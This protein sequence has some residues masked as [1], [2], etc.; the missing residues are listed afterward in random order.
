MKAE[1][2][3]RRSPVGLVI[4]VS[5]VV[6]AVGAAYWVNRRGHLYPTS[7]DATIDA[8]VVHV[9]PS[10]PGRVIELPV[11]ENQLVAR[12]DLLFRLDPEHY[13]HDVRQAEADL[14]LARAEV[15]TQRRLIATETA[16]LAVVQAQVTKARTNYDLSFRTV[17]RLRP[18][19]DK[20]FVPTQQFDQAEVN[21]RDMATSLVQVTAQERA[22]RSA[23]GKLDA[24][25]AAVKAREAA[26]AN[27][28]RAL[29]QTVVLAPVAGRV[30]GMN[31]TVGES[32]VPSQSLFTLISTEEWFAVANMRE[33]SLAHIDVGDCATVYSMIDRTKPLRGK[34]V[35]IGWGVLDTDRLNPPR[36]LPYVAR[37]LDWVHVEQRFPVRV[38]LE[39]PP[40]RLVRVGATA[41]VE[42]GHGES[43]R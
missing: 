17:E 40:E 28:Q 20:A 25:E 6:I 18:L 39:D 9:A 11:K 23:I 13:E 21:L 33:V 27:A 12:G 14:A 32:L 36:S 4:F 41:S 3:K 10:V 16:N 15:D 19:Q 5:L 38:A 1:G 7:D 24:V 30:T 29:R 43:C 26:L 31:V 2:K 35:S 8:D 34:V 37:T 22:A 42:V